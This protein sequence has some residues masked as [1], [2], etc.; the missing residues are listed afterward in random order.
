[1]SMPV[2]FRPALVAGVIAMLAACASV[3]ADGGPAGPAIADGQDF[4]LQAG[5]SA[6]LA[7]GSSLRYVRVVNDSR[8]RPD[9]QCVWAGDAEVAFEWHASGGRLQ[10]FSLHTTVGDKSARIGARRLTLLSLERGDAPAAGL[11]IGRTE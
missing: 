4:S 3:P 10:A 5:S 2:A 7:D 11:R 1:M 6:T 8:C 9:V